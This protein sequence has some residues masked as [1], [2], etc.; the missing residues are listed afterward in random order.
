MTS[1]ERQ[2]LSVLHQYQPLFKEWI[3]ISR[4]HYWFHLVAPVL[5]A[6]LYGANSIEQVLTPISLWFVLYFFLPGN[7]FLY[8][9]NDM[10][11]EET[12]EHNPRKRSEGGIEGKFNQRFETVIAIIGS[13]L[14]ITTVIF[15]TTSVPVL[16]T[17]AAWIGINITYNMPPF[18]FKSVPLLDSI[19]N[20]V[21]ILPGIAAY[22]AVSETIPPILAIVGFWIWTMGYHTLAATA[23]I[24][25]DREAN[26]QTLATVLGKRLSLTY[27][28][29]TWL[30][31]ALALAEV[32]VYAGAL[33]AVYP[34]LVAIAVITDI[35]VQDLLY[36][37]PIINL[38]VSIPIFVGGLWP[39]LS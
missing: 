6:I 11:D 36:Y 33:F 37:I 17:I 30:I 4:P 13:G 2:N 16:L 12:D 26:I 24:K 14:L 19:S 39:L 38:L 27:C 5:F 9:I 1:E 31:A 10:Y 32:Y 7:L 21:Y 35:D 34:A 22:I 8:G 3:R 15:F 20:G 28:G 29:L 23:D 18:R 25:P